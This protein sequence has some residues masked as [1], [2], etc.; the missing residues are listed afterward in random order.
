ME[1]K[2]TFVLKER[3]AV[4]DL[5]S[6]ALEEHHAF[7]MILGAAWRPLGKKRKSRI[8]NKEEAMGNRQWAIGGRTIA[9]L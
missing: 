1:K 7:S 8:S 4:R 3:P 5:K 2:Y 9:S 6:A